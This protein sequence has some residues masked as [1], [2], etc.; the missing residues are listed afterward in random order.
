MSFRRLF[1]SAAS[2]LL[3]AVRSRRA[4]VVLILYFAASLLCMNVAIS[5]LSKVEV[6]VS[7]A[8]QVEVSDASKEGAASASLWRSKKFQKII[9]ANI[10]DPRLYDEIKDRHPAELLY[11]AIT[12]FFI[13]LLTIL[14]GA[15]RIA[16]DL[17][18]GAVRYMITRVTRLEWSLGKYLGMALLLVLG[19]LLGAFAAWAVAFFRL[20]GAD[21]AR[22][23]PTMLLWSVKAWFLSLAWLGFAMCFSHMFRSGAAAT[24]TAIGAFVGSYLLSGAFAFFAHMGVLPGLFETLDLLHP[25]SWKEGLWRASPA[26]LGASAAFLLMLGLLYHLLGYATFARRDAR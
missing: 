4:I 14:V 9:R 12:F 16:D 5:I 11:A 23:L 1:L 7:E 15:N 17:R 8:L 19:L 3:S 20:G 18:S 24:A 21:I 10:E 2:E 6:H 26:P 25:S 22:L 13:P